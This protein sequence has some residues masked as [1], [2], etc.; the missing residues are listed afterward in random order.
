M[1][2]LLVGYGYWGKIWEKTIQ[3]SNHQI[4]DIIDTV[5]FNNDIYSVDFDNFD[6]VIIASPINTHY[7]LAEFFIKKNKNVLIEKPC[8]H[9]LNDIQKLIE[10]NSNKNIGVGYVLVYCSAI[11]KLKNNNIKW[12]NAFFNRSNGSTQIRKDCNVIYD[13]LCH[14][15][16]IAFYIF[17]V[18]PQILFCK[19]NDNSITCILNFDGTICHFYCSR[20]DNKKRSNCSFINDDITY[21]YDD[22]TKN[23]KIYEK[24]KITE[25][26]FHEYPLNNQLNFLENKFI[27]D[28]KFA[29]NIHN[30]LKL[31]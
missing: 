4:Y 13:L 7:E 15:I 8:T 27:S 29:E 11:R 2:I 28:L 18:M 30:I 9:N 17:N 1:K 16:S 22:I 20:I 6:S 5:V 3:N 19:K 23:L 14:D 31:L 26:T 12:K 25:K 10:I 21:Y 24:N